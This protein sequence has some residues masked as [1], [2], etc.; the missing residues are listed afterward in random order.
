MLGLP[1]LEAES[2]NQAWLA[3]K[4]IIFRC[5]FP[6]EILHVDRIFSIAIFDYQRAGY[7]TKQNC[8]TKKTTISPIELYFN[9]T[10]LVKH[11]PLFD[12][13]SDHSNRYHSGSI[14]PCT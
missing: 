4:S 6:D 5:F 12:A 10:F 8:G 11:M 14:P 1:T 3:G 2:P 7:G 13:I 9:L